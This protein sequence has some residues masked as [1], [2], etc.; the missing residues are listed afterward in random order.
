MIDGVKTVPLR[1]MPDER[2]WLMEVL[3]CDD[4]LFVKFGQAYV[5]VAY[6]G[7]VKAWHCHELQ[8]DHF[9]VLTGMAKVVLYDGR[10]D[11]PTYGEINEFFAGVHNRILIR[12][13][14]YVY[15]GFKAIGTQECMIMNI[16][17]EP[18]NR[19]KPDELRLDPHNGPIPYDWSR[20]DG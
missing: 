10:E 2:G 13:P 4:E 18:Y 15:H 5:T 20:K 17:T 6:P 19:D 11:S 7:V 8:T 3:R 1:L 16:P 12:I 9:A 14:P